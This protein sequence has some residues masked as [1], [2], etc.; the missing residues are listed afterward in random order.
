MSTAALPSFVTKPKDIQVT[1]G[2]VS[3]MEC[4]VTG[5]PQPVYF[6]SKESSQVLMFP[7]NT[8]GKFSVSN[9]GILSIANVEKEDQGFY[10]CSS[11]SRVGS[12]ITRAFLSVLVHTDVPPPIIRLGAANQTLPQSTKAFLPCEASTAFP[13]ATIQ[14]FFNQKQIHNDTHYTITSTS[15]HIQSKLYLL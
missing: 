9:D 7:G 11:V 3:K 4:L 13:Q 8:Y 1:A 12:D 2:S 10:I 14:W 15:L 6:W 5:N